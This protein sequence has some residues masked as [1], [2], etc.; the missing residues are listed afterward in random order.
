LCESK[1]FN[2]LNSLSASK[3][4][5]LDGLPSRFVRDESPIITGPIT[6]IVNL[7]LIKGLIADDLKNARV[8]L[9]FKKN[10][11]LSFGNYRPLPILIVV[12]KILE[13]VVYN[14]VESY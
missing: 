13:K 2:Y 6:H 7:S 8:V 4:T 3:A 1:V 12:S 11:K 10:D 14:Q 9:L 5:G